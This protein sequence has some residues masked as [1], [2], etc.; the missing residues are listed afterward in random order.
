MIN[1]EEIRRH[2]ILKKHLMSMGIN[3]IISIMDKCVFGIETI[4]SNHLEIIADLSSTALTITTRINEIN[5]A[6]TLTTVSMLGELIN[7]INLNLII[8]KFEID[9]DDGSIWFYVSVPYYKSFP[10]REI[11]YR[12]IPLICHMIDKYLPGI[13]SV[14]KGNLSPKD[15]YEKCENHDM[16]ASNINQHISDLFESILS[17]YDKEDNS[18]DNSSLD[19][20][21]ELVTFS[22]EFRS[23]IERLG[24]ET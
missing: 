22:E 24:N 17:V 10:E 4:H 12:L 20:Q 1:S 3:G 11:Y 13:K 6:V 2:N 15:A 8:G 14:V 18:T 16:I 7:R 9:Y 5:G 21:E 19:E 23:L